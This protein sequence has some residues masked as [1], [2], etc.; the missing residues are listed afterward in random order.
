MRLGVVVMRST[1]KNRGDGSDS[2]FT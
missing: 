1:L 2:N